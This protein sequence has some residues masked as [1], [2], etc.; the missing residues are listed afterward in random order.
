[1]RHG[2]DIF[3]DYSLKLGVTFLINNNKVFDI[4]HLNDLESFMLKPDVDT[5]LTKTSLENW[6]FKLYCVWSNVFT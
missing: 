1:M 3:S 6:L 4:T 2:I 5:S